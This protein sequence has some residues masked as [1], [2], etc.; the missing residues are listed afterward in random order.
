MSKT[1]LSSY[2]NSWYPPT[3]GASTWKRLLWYACSLLIFRSGWMPV[4]MLKCR[5]LRLFGAGIGKGVVIKP[6]V[7]IKYPWLLNI[8]EN[9]WIGEGVWIDN[10]C[11]VS[12]GDNVCVSQ[13]ALLLTG[14][15]NYKKSSFDLMVGNII[16]ENGVW[17]G[18]KSVVCPGITC[19]SHSI[20]T[21]GSVA[22]QNLQAYT[23]YQGNPAQV[24]KKREISTP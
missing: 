6:K 18:A 17:I 11:R 19:F 1:D 14:N 21:V 4:S 22:T 15:H 16:L 12:I 10:L 20:L 3:I 7:T 2:N 13:G 23:I 5:L 24:V 9:T 8:G